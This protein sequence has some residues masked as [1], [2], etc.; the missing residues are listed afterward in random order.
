MRARAESNK[1]E[2]EESEEDEEEGEED[3]AFSDR[4]EGE[5]MAIWKMEFKTPMA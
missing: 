1:E 3:R 2:E 5:Y 4:E